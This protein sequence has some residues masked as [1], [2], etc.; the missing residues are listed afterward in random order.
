MKFVVVGQGAFELAGLG[1]FLAGFF[2]DLGWVMV[3]GGV[4][5]IV[6]DLVEMAMGVLNPLFPVILAVVLAVLV[7]PW[8]V[9]VFWSSAAFKVFGIPGSLTKVFSPSVVVE[10]VRSRDN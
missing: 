1:A 4:A 5:I 2:F 9:G 10:R 6:D 3:L 7:T 8:Y